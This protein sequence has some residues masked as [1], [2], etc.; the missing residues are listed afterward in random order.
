M[1]ELHYRKLQ[2]AILY[3]ASRSAG[4]PQFA[5]TR[6]AKSLFWSD[7]R[8]FRETRQAITGATYIRIPYGPAPFRFN[9]FLKNME[10]LHLIAID[11]RGDQKRPI[12]SREPNLDN[13]SA[14]ELDTLDRVIA[15]QWG[16]PAWQVSEESHK[17]IGWR[18]ADRQDR[19]PYGTIWLVD[20]APEP[21]EQEQQRALALAA[22]LGRA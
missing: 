4:D 5:R 6:L 11:A 10:G 7:F 13:F 21:T 20:P 8:Y 3:V 14:G 22:R 17:F 12:A 1:V 2:E 9:D 19:I 15:E 16:K 18:I